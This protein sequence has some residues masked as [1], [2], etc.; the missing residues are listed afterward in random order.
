MARK[1]GS[2]GGR[3]ATSRARRTRARA[4]ARS[5]QRQRFAG[6]GTEAPRAWGRSRGEAGAYRE[7]YELAGPRGPGRQRFEGREEGRGGHGGRGRYEGRG[8]R[9][10][11]EYRAPGYGGFGGERESRERYLSGERSMGG[12][13]GRSDYGGF[14]RRRQEGGRDYDES[15][16]RRWGGWSDE[17]G[18]GRAYY[19]GPGY[20]DV[21][22]ER[23][24]FE[25]RGR[26]GRELS[27]H[28]RW[29][30]RE[31][32]HERMDRFARERYGRRGERPFRREEEPRRYREG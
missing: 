24:R 10:Y 20:Q 15:S 13:Q 22:E 27:G 30:D 12:D 29:D 14:G 5:S 17:A 32:A 16:E 11:G 28:E 8:E 4:G 25:P 7:A 3:R 26:S 23:G 9:E 2:K 6:R 1:T 18:Y 19:G 21:E 31:Q